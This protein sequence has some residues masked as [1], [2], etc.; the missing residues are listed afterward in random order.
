[1]H[2]LASWLT[3]EYKQSLFKCDRNCH[4]TI[5]SSSAPFTS[6][7]KRLRF[8]PAPPSSCH[9]Q[10]PQF[11]QIQLHLLK[12]LSFLQATVMQTL[13]SFLRTSF[14][15]ISCVLSFLLKKNLFVVFTFF[16]KKNYHS[17]RTAKAVGILPQREKLIW[18]LYK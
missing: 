3:P 17:I 8:L 9:P 10:T 14:F 6:K 18:V 15:L 2:I 5:V 7:C 11:F 1:M 12:T 16:Q 4:L 13:L